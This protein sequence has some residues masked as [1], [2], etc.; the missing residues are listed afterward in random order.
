MAAR[1][2]TGPALIALVEDGF[3]LTPQELAEL[4]QLAA[5]SRGSTNVP[6]AAPSAAHKVSVAA[7][8]VLPVEP[9][10]PPPPVPRKPLGLIGRAPTHTL[11]TVVPIPEDGSFIIS[12]PQM[13]EH[14]CHR[15]TKWDRL[16]DAIRAR[17]GTQELQVTGDAGL[18]W[19][20]VCRP[21][22]GNG[23]RPPA[24]IAISRAL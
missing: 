16:R 1:S 2:D 22:D 18:L 19:G 20:R 11:P 8:P 17:A 9:A 3:V 12:C 6:T 21:E 15:L 14:R 24:R 4:R 7:E 5:N 23:L 13:E 10:P